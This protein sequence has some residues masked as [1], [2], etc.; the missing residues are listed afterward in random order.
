MWFQMR[1]EGLG[2]LG[3]APVVHRTEVAVAA[4]RAE[5]FAA[6]AEPGGWKHWFP[7]VREASY[8]TPPP[9]GVGTIRVADVGGTRWVEEMIAWDEGTRWAWTVTRAS[10]PFA[11]AQVEC[12]ELMAAGAETCVRWTLALEPRLL[13]RL[14]SPFAAR[15]IPRLF[16]RAMSNL[17]RYLQAGARIRA[18]EG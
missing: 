2:F 12:F 1:R 11:R 10:V 14:G 4:P 6:L 16:R 9:H 13:A 7:R 17:G 15:V 5:V 3:R 8:T 18:I